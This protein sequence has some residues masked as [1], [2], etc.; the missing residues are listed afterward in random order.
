MLAVKK[1]IIEGHVSNATQCARELWNNGQTSSDGFSNLFQLTTVKKL[2]KGL[3]AATSEREGN[4]NFLYYPSP[5]H[6][7]AFA[8]STENLR[9]D[10]AHSYPG[11]VWYAK[12]DLRKHEDFL[13]IM[14]VQGLFEQ[15]PEVL[16]RSLITKYAGGRAHL[17]KHAFE[18][19]LERGISKV[20]LSV[21]FR[22]GKIYEGGSDNLRHFVEQG[23]TLGFTKLTHNEEENR[24]ELEKEL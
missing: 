13:T 4:I 10:P 15:T 9:A 16:P 22:G 1:T 17:F 21:G 11:G 2:R 14:A 8:A 19:A 18:Y 6:A 3:I 5:E 12:L 20:H 24:F 23:K 7:G